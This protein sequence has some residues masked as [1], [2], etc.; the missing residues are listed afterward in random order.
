MKPS[1]PL[2]ALALAAC[3]KPTLEQRTAPSAVSTSPA[4]SPPASSPP[5]AVESGRPDATVARDTP[6]FG[7]KTTG[8]VSAWGVTSAGIPALAKDGTRI[9]AIQDE[10]DG[11]RGY[12]NHAVVVKTVRTDALEKRL[13]VFDADALD[14]AERAG[15]LDAERHRV[16]G[17]AAAV[18][19]LLSTSSWVA[20]PEAVRRGNRFV[21]PDG[22]TVTLADA[23]LVVK[24]AAGKTLLDHDAKPWRAAP[25]VIPIPGE[26][27]GRPC[28]FEPML[29]RV[30]VGR[31]E[32]IVVVFVVQSVFGTDSCGAPPET[33][34][35]TWH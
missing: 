9:L 18:S 11:M 24:D 25:H 33:H 19:A 8:N 34:V 29:E 13:P 20:I 7:V 27:G 30:H 15:T 12:A 23:R 26:P 31:E 21:A 17:R 28:R 3:A 14:R 2:V 1:A 32:R 22:T 16:D 10:G 5:V 35:L 6:A 4:A